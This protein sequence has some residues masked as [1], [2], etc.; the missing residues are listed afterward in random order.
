MG[1]ESISRSRRDDSQA[2]NFSCW[3]KENRSGTEGALGK[4]QEGK[5]SA[6]GKSHRGYRSRWL[7]ACR[8]LMCILSYEVKTLDCGWIVSLD[9]DAL[10]YERAGHEHALQ[11]SGIPN[12]P[13]CIVDVG[14]R[15][16]ISRV[17]YRA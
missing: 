5:M 10:R 11:T 8:K 12:L 9:A 4:N 6:K 1:K 7:Y 15:P 17:S 2:D 13:R 14:V 3:P 16:M